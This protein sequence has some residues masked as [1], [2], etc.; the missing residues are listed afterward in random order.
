VEESACEDGTLDSTCCVGCPEGY[1]Q[2]K[3]E[4]EIGSD[5]NCE[6]CEAGK[7][8]GSTG[9]SE[10]DTCPEGKASLEGAWTCSSPL[11]EHVDEIVDELLDEKTPSLSA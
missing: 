2:D 1:Y 5:E 6:A 7:F 4:G 10:C 8:S 9:A 11:D 3:A